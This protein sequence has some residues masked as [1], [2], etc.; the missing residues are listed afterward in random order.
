[1]NN[2]CR[3]WDVSGLCESCY[4]GYVVD[5]GKCVEDPNKFVPDKD[6]LCAEYV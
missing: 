2:L 3:T 1:M 4:R 5:D 6:D